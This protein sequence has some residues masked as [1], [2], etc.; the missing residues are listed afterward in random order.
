MNYWMEQS[1]LYANQK[2]YLDMLFSVYP[3]SVNPPREID[4]ER[5]AFIEQAF[6]H[7]QRTQQLKVCDVYQ[8]NASYLSR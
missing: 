4:N 7:F 3:M 2:N 8:V 5:W 1:I 6:E